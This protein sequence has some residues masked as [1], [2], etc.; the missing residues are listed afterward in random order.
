MRNY[1]SLLVSVLATL[2][3]CISMKVSA[4]QAPTASQPLQADRKVV[5]K[6]S[7]NIQNNRI[8]GPAS[9]SIPA[10]GASS[11]AQKVLKAKTKS[12]QSND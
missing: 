3:L 12:N 10:S 9:A 11:S 1:A 8:V 6:T 2:C 4:Q 7:S 5:T